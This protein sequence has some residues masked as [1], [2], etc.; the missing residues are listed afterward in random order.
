[1]RRLVTFSSVLGRGDVISIHEIRR[2]AP[3]HYEAKADNAR[4]VA[5]MLANNI[6]EE[7]CS[8]TAME[9]KYGGTPGIA[10]GEAFRREAALALELIT[11]AVIA[12]KI[13]LDVA[14]AH[15]VAVRPTHD[16]NELWR[17]AALPKLSNED[18]RR[19][20][21]AKRILVWA[22]RYAAPKNDEVYE[23]EELEDQRLQ[24]IRP[25]AGLRFVRPV[26]FDWVNFDRLYQIAARDFWSLRDGL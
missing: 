2:R 13:E 12:Q 23:K 16:L 21:L 10:I 25:S 22:G 17:E 7:S 8:S 18:Q 20:L 24:Q 3:L 26:A 6:S 1:M 9:A 11:K 14:P 19:L 15:V 5:C 4:F